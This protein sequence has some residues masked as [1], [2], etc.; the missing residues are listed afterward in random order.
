M[1]DLLVEQVLQ[2]LNGL[3]G[4]LSKR[5]STGLCAYAAAVTG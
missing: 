4:G 1:Q 5:S 3:L 2:S